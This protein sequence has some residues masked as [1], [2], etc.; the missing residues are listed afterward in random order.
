M[1]KRAWKWY[2]NAWVEE[3]WPYWLTLA[4]LAQLFFLWAGWEVPRLNP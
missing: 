4:I 1:L 3:E 2:Q